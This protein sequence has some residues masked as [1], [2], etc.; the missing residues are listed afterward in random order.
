MFEA[1]FLPILLFGAFIGL[2]VFGIF[3][4]RVSTAKFDEENDGSS[5]LSSGVGGGLFAL[6]EIIQ[7]GV[8]HVVEA[9]DHQQEDEEDDEGERFRR[10]QRLKLRPDAESE[11]E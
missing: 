7:P 5:K 6:Q 4:C 9:E 8:R 1:V 3:K 2:I 10:Q 11:R